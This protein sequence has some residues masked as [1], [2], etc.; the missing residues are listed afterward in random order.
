MGVLG[1]CGC[2]WVSECGC[3]RVFGCLWV[4]G[5]VWICWVYVGGSVRGCVWVSV[6]GC[7]GVDL[8]GVWVSA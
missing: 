2:V 4:S 6:C 7:L 3:L 5:R 1:V 8:L